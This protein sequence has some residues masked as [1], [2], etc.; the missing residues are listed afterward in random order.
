MI[1]AADEEQALPIVLFDQQFKNLVKNK[2]AALNME[3]Y[4]PSGR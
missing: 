4:V 2:T 1:H 3:I